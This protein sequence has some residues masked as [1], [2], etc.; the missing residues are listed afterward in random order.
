MSI[1]RWLQ[2]RKFQSVLMMVLTLA[3]LV[4][5]EP[6]IG[7]T[8][9]EPDYIVASEAY[10]SWFGKLITQPA[11][12]LSKDG[13]NDSWSFN[14]EHPPLDKIWSGIVWSGARFVFDD[15]TAHRLGN[16]ILVSIMVGLLYLLIAESY[17]L[18]ADSPPPRCSPCRFFFH[19]H[20]AALDIPAAPSFRHLPFWKPGRPELE[21]DTHPGLIWGLAFAPRSMPS[22]CHLLYFYGRS[23]SADD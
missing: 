18:A 11:A 7:L 16:M 10:S 23:S 5:T 13:I 6:Q 15:L 19:A 20:L 3:L 17:G 21:M 1:P 9:D 2:N 8:W 14:H 4:A 12:A 22:S